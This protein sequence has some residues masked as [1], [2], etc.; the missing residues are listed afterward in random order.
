MA[1]K[2]LMKDNGLI[3]IWRLVNPREREYTFYS[4]N[5]KSHS[6]IVYFLISKDL[7][8]TVS[9]C[10][11]GPIALTDHA[12]VQLGL[13]LESD[14]VK[15]NRWRM[16]ISLF[17]DPQFNNLIK[18]ELDQFFQL[19][20]GS[21]DRVGTVW[22]ASKAY[23]R[24]KIIA[25]SSRKKREQTQRINNL[26]S[27]LKEL[28]KTIFGKYNDTVFK[29]ICDLKLQINEIYNKKAEYA[30][31]RLKRNFYVVSGEW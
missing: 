3:D 8:E 31:F 5:H 26:E 17:Q 27:W 2:L 23:I 22:E 14:R 13:I 24:G 9:D 19:N 12:A 29:Q 30:P 16:N 4:H 18:E 1:I 10:L 6:R 20:I 15:K 21:T 28:E 11:I 25:Y 7:V